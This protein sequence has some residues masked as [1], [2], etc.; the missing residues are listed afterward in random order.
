MTIYLGIRR[1]A[2]PN[3]DDLSPEIGAIQVRTMDGPQTE[4]DDISRFRRNSDHVRK[5][6]LIRWQVRCPAVSKMRQLPLFATAGN[7]T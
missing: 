2:V 1:I 4:E 5:L 6:E 3:T 7:K